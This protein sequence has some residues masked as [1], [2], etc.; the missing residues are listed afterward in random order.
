[1]LV[2]LQVHNFA[3]IED[4]R[5]DFSRG[6]NVFTGETG[7]GKSILVDAFG[8]VLGGRANADFIRS[9]TEGFWVQA[10]FTNTTNPL[11]DAFLQEQG[12]DSEEEV[13]LK[14]IVNAQGKSKATINGVQ[15]PLQVLR[16]AGNLL[17]NIH[18]QHENQTLLHQ[19]MPRIL[20]DA[21]GG[22]KTSDC[23]ANYQKSYQSLKQAKGA[24]EELL[25]DNRNREQLLGLYRH[26]I[27]EIDE[28]ELQEGEEEKLRDEAKILQHGEKIIGSI[29]AVRNYVDGEGACLSNLAAARREL[30][31]ALGFD[32]ALQ[33][34]YDSVDSAWLTLDDARE[35]LGSYL[36]G[37]DF[38]PERVNEVQSRLD[39]L[40]DLEKKYG[41]DVCE[42]LAY[43][44]MAAEKLAALES[45]DASIAKLEKE[46]KEAE[47]KANLL[48]DKLTKI[49]KIFAVELG[50]KITGHIQDLAMPE[51]NFEIRIAEGELGAF[52]RDQLQFYFTANR[53]E[54]SQELGKVA[55]GGE[56]SRV[57]LAVKTVLLTREDVGTM[58][59]DEIDAG[60]GGVTAERMAEKI[61]LLAEHNQ[62]LC[63]TH[64]PQIAAF[65]QQHIYIEKRTEADRTITE[66]KVLDKNE[67]IGELAR[68]AAGSNKSAAALKT[69]KELLENA[70]KKIS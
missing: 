25:Q 43:R 32:P 31:Y 11:L 20:T 51:G 48:A 36:D 61:A 52:G 5:V 16:Q 4:A 59:F 39:L 50:K 21:Y 45:I 65:A 64:L 27:E 28:A 67:R 58:V 15:V 68:M 29:N 40:Y 56:L 46:V 47:E 35:E 44:D 6:F 10:I 33:S 53:G 22:K 62:V 49:R 12:I 60:V 54:P 9:G 42:I 38:N 14:R 18:G 30:E 37:F 23:L 8:V 24:L 2:S 41:R 19:D 57:A 66:L 1:M 63:I 13:F 17:V 7:A 26:T 3:L 69:A 34:I 70:N 55:S